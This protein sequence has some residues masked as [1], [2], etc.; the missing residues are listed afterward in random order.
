MK[1]TT[2]L[3]LFTALTVASYA[4]TITLIDFGQSGNT[5]EDAGWNNVTDPSTLGATTNLVDQNDI[6]TGEVLELTDVF[7]PLPNSTGTSTPDGSLPFLDTATEDSFFGEDVDFD[8]GAGLNNEPTGAFTLSGLEAGKYYSFTIFASRAGLPE[9][10]DNREA[11]YTITGSTTET[12]TLDASNNTGEVAT[13]LNIQPDINGE[14]TIEVE[15]GPANNNSFG[16][17]YIGAMEITKSDNTLS[18]E[19]KRLGINGTVSITYPNTKEFIKINLNLNESAKVK[20]DVFN[21]TGKKLTTLLN[22]EKSVGPFSKVWDTS[23]FASGVYI[24][25]ISANGRT[26]NA[27]FVIQ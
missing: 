17:Y 13:I 18:S 19:T 24:L 22:E 26:Q 20:M 11:L 21:I 25:N 12:A 27:K 3:L 7:D 15:K 9:P 1:K 16:F 4:Q 5:T 10:A 6:P 8:S 23:G 2:L 14:I